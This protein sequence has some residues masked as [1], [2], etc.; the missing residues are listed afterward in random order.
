MSAQQTESKTEKAL[1]AAFAGESQANRKYL[2]F[3]KKA[4]RDGFPGVAKLFR[5]AANA[6]T[7]HALR[8]LN[9]LG[10][11]RS[12]VDNIREAIEGETYEYT[13]MYRDFAED[14]RNEGNQAALKTFEWAKKVEEVHANWYKR[15]LE[16]AES[17]QDLRPQQLWV[18]QKCGNILE[19]DLPDRCPVC[20]HPKEFFMAID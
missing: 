3:A 6:E 10:G 16:L 5:A 9:D 12:T 17:G 20:S 2:A 14:A 19:G 18:C 15:A 11:I 8:E 13:T 7:V 1:K 4:D